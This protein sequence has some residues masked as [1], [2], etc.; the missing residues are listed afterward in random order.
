MPSKMKVS[1]VETEEKGKFVHELL[2]KAI[3]FFGNK[4]TAIVTLNN[5]IYVFETSS[6]A[7]KSIIEDENVEKYI[8]IPIPTLINY[9]IE[10]YNNVHISGLIVKERN[11]ENFDN[12][13]NQL[14]NLSKENHKDESD[15]VI[16]GAQIITSYIISYI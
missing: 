7:L 4:Y 6:Q 15:K 16:H 10:K 14:I 1:Y 11:Y 9:G 2:E 13:R 8:S 5:L 3:L 12:Y